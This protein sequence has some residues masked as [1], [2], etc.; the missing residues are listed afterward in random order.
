M[1]SSIDYLLPRLSELSSAHSV[2]SG[3]DADISFRNFPYRAFATPAFQVLSER[4]IR[5]RHPLQAPYEEGRRGGPGVG[6]PAFGSDPSR[7]WL[8]L[9]CLA[10]TFHQTAATRDLDYLP[11]M[12]FHSRTGRI[13]AQAGIG[14]CR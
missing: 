4:W 6:N 10:D 13:G 8:N 11:T 3:R 7:A 5:H 9:L 1:L 14:E 12:L 2:N